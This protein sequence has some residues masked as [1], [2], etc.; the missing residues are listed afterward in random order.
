M[1]GPIQDYNGLYSGDLT[2]T[3]EM[4]GTTTTQGAGTL[5]VSFEQI[6]DQ[7]TLDYNASAGLVNR[8]SMTVVD[9]VLYSGGRQVGQGGSFALVIND[10]NWTYTFLRVTDQ[11]SGQHVVRVTAATTQGGQS[12]KYLGVLFPR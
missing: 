5:S 11:A 10:Q 12:A 9:H 8:Y 3:L 7:L 1:I 2:L 4:N 6:G